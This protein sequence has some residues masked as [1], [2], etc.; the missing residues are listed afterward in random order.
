MNP[1]DAPEVLSFTSTAVEP[2]LR[3]SLR[4]AHR[5]GDALPVP[6]RGGWQSVRVLD[7]V[8]NG[9]EGGVAVTVTIIPDDT[10]TG[11]SPDRQVAAI[12]SR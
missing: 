11:A 1:A 9:I 12:R 3:L 7:Y 6:R 2:G 5:N 10:V 8:E 4:R